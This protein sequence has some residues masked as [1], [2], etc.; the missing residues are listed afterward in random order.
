MLT[1]LTS[2][3][4]AG[5]KKSVKAGGLQPAAVSGTDICLAEGVSKPA[6]L[7]DSVVNFSLTF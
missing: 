5:G 6:H 4:E 3:S 1:D 7:L 2:I